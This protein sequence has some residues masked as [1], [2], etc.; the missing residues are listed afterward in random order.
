MTDKGE[1]LYTA[2]VLEVKEILP[3]LQPAITMSNCERGSRNAFKQVY[4]GTTIYGCWFHY[5]QV[6]SRHI[7][8]FGLVSSYR[9]IPE[10]AV[11]VRQI[12]ANP[13]LPCD[14][15]HST[16]SCLQLPMLPHNEKCKL[17]AFFKEYWLTQV[18][19]SELSIWSRK[20]S[21][22]TEMLIR[23]YL[24]FMNIMNDLLANYDKD[25]SRLRHG[26][27]ITRSQIKHVRIN[28]E[29]R[30]ECKQKLMIGTY[31]PREFFGYIIII[32]FF[33]FGRDRKIK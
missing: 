22:E 10:L 2:V 20:L 33:M 24:Y 5:S 11:F 13:F 28:I 30:Q 26:N 21:C 29:Y 17:N 15:L 1:E 31:T 16:Y 4:P 8:K 9:N 7:Q 32:K 3:Q 27:E 12:M 6:I 18:T 25:I 19:P 23:I 14:L